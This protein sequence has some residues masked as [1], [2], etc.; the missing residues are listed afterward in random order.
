M[1][2]PKIDKHIFHM[3]SG[4]MSL[5]GLGYSAAGYDNALPQLRPYVGLM[6]D[7][8]VFARPLQKSDFLWMLKR[9]FIKAVG[10]TCDKTSN[11]WETFPDEFKICSMRCS[12]RLWCK[13][14]EWTTSEGQPQCLLFREQPQKLEKV[15]NGARCAVLLE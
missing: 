1:N 9:K 10:W 13:G 12:N 15:G 3:T 11:I 4:R 8:M 5:G 7:F 14:Y 6:D 2:E